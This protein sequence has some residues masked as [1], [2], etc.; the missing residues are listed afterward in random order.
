VPVTIDVRLARAAHQGEELIC[1]LL[2]P[3]V[4]TPRPS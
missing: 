2:R 4:C 1:W 3:A